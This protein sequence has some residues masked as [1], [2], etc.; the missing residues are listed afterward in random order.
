MQDSLLFRRGARFWE[1]LGASG[2]RALPGFKMF[3]TA[4]VENVSEIF[5]VSKS[6][7]SGFF[8]NIGGLC[9]PP[10]C[11]TGEDRW[12]GLVSGPKR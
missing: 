12:E 10:F 9:E 1:E 11:H 2:A 3:P 4:R 5:A 8:S 7:R 6:G